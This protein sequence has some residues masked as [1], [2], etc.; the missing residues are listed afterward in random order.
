MKRLEDRNFTWPAVKNGTIVLTP[1][2]LA[3]LLEGLDWWRIIPAKTITP[4]MAG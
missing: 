3:M 2:Q 4:V 1:A